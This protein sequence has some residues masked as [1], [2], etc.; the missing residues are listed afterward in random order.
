MALSRISLHFRPAVY[1]KGNVVYSEGDSAKYV[2]FVKEGAFRFVKTATVQRRPDYL[3]TKQQTMTQKLSEFK[4]KSL[5]VAIK[6]AGEMFGEGEI[7]DN[8]GRHAT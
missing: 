6:G 7:L 8:E 4:Y 2:Y 3:P 1:R 5:Q